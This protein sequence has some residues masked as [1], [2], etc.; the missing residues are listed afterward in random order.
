MYCHCVKRSGQLPTRA[1]LWID[2]RWSGAHGIGRYATEILSRL[3]LPWLPLPANGGPSDPVDFLRRRVVSKNGLVYSP[4]YN[5]GVSQA[6]QIITI[7]DL[8]HLST[9]WPGRA[10]YLAY[11]DLVAR[12]AIRRAKAVFTVSDATSTVIRDWLRDDSVEVINAGE[13]VSEAFSL[14]GPAEPFARPTILTVG[15]LRKH[16]NLAVLVSALAL[17]DSMDAVFIVPAAEMEDLAGIVS[18]SQLTSRVSILSGVSDER[19]AELYRGAAVTAF[20]TVLEGFGLPALE[21]IQCGT[22]VV[23][24]AGCPSVGEIV[25]DRGVAVESAHDASQW[26][27]ALTRAAE[28]PRVSPFPPSD[29]S[30][31]RAASTIQSYLTARI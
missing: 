4:G 22:P 18:T 13:G 12:P 9:P 14:D 3:T 8:I 5:A 20:P 28:G 17:I 2:D 31:D 1:D 7:H 29:H 23:H 27:E 10:K 21:S 15:N 19:L 24:W 11:Y 30:W 16:K 26:A 25:G 6:R